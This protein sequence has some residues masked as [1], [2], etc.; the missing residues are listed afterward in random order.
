MRSAL[1]QMLIAQVPPGDGSQEAL[2][3]N[4]SEFLR[5][6]FRRTQGS[7]G[8]AFEIPLDSL[9]PEKF[10]EVWYVKGAVDASFSNGIRWVKSRDHVA[11]YLR[12]EINGSAEISTQTHQAYAQLLCAFSSLTDFRIARTWNFVP[13]INANPNDVENYWQFNTGRARAYRDLPINEDELPA[14]TAIGGAENTALTIIAIAS[15][16]DFE[17]VENPRQTSAYRYP[18]EYGP[19]RPA[20]ARGVKLYAGN[21]QSLIVSGTSSIVGHKSVHGGDVISQCQESTKNILSL[22]KQSQEDATESPLVCARNGYYRAYVRHAEDAA[23]V[24]S[25]LQDTLG[26]QRGLTVLQGDICR[27][28]LLVEVEGY[29][30]I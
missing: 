25:V 10:D 8:Q 19:D 11:A 3:N 15:R 30:Q 20:F 13:G 26:C 29:C 22:I 24:S 6:R 1:P 21:H 5:F 7:V 4:L 28:E 2:E 17:T 18:R 12:R 9:N 14:A 16:I 27:R 23:A